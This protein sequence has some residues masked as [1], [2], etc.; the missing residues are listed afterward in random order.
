MASGDLH[1]NIYA[2]LRKHFKKNRNQL[3]SMWP[4]DTSVPFICLLFPF[5]FCLF[6]TSWPPRAAS[7]SSWSAFLPW[8]PPHPR[9][10]K[11]LLCPPGARQAAVHHQPLQASGGDP[12]QPL[13]HGSPH[14]PGEEISLC[15]GPSHAPLF[16]LLP[17][18]RPPS[19]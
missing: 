7:P 19:R 10:P 18:P 4:S 13:R 12:E 6:N 16:P 3:D 5:A 1:R 2:V 11:P 17:L 14:R 15:E 8:K 9:Q